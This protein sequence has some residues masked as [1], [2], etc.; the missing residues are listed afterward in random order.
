M[1]RTIPAYALVRFD[2]ETVANLLGVSS[3]A[4]TRAMV[5]TVADALTRDAWMLA[6]LTMQEQGLRMGIDAEPPGWPAAFLAA[7]ARERLFPDLHEPDQPEST[8]APGHG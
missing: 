2:P 8:H 4:L 7:V 6:D 3:E 1:N 5:Q